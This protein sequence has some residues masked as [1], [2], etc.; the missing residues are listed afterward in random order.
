MR[1]R[2]AG[3]RSLPEATS[4]SHPMPWPAAS[5]AAAADGGLFSSSR[6]ASDRSAERCRGRMSLALP[7][8]VVQRRHAFAKGRLRVEQRH[9]PLPIELVVPQGLHDLFGVFPVVAVA[10]GEPQVIAVEQG[11]QG[12]QP[13]V[14]LIGAPRKELPR[15]ASRFA[16]RCQAIPS[17]QRFHPQVLGHQTDLRMHDSPLT[18][19]TISGVVGLRFAVCRDHEA[20][21]QAGIDEGAVDAVARIRSQPHAAVSPATAGSRAVASRRRGRH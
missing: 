18:G 20:I 13:N 1:C 10:H 9:D 4:G 19:G 2:S 7:F 6:S 15:I 8:V 11:G 17:S 14:E 3:W 5:S 12:Q 21:E 16:R